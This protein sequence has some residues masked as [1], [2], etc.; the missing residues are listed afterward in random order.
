MKYEYKAF[1]VQ[2]KGIIDT[3]LP[4]EFMAQVNEFGK[5]GWELVQILPLSENNGKTKRVIFIF[6]KEK[7]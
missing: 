1:E 2:T 4:V 3:K 6:K 5:Q 7:A